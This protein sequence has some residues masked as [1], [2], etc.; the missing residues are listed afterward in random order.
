MERGN[1]IFV[2]VDGTMAV[3][4]ERTR[5]GSGQWEASGRPPENFLAASHASQFIVS[6]RGLGQASGRPPENFLA[7]LAR[8]STHRERTRVRPGQWEASREFF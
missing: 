7:C 6:A 1:A 2:I 8:E 3:S 4:R 5:V